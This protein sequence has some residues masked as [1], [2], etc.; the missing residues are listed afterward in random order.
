MLDFKGVHTNKKNMY[1]Q[2]NKILLFSKK[3]T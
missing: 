2:T 3:L 1:R